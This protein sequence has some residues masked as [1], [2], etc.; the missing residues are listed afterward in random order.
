MIYQDFQELKEKVLSSSKSIYCAVVFPHDEY[1]MDAVLKAEHDG[2]I[3]PIFIGDEKII[4]SLFRKRKIEATEYPVYNVPYED[5]A[6]ALAIDMVHG[7]DAECILKG[8]IT[9][10][11]FMRELLR[12][13]NKFNEGNIVSLLSFHMLENYH[14]I[15]AF[16][17]T[18][19]CPHPNLKQ[20]TLIL[21]NAVNFLHTIG[22]N[23]PKVAI[24]SPSDAADATLP[25]SIDAAAISNMNEDGSIGGCTICGPISFDAAL[26]KEAATRKN[27]LSPVAGDADL[28]VF[29]SLS[30]ASFTSKAI[31]LVT[32]Q[33][34]GTIM[35]G[36]KVPVILSSR[37]SSAE[38][39]YLGICLVIASMLSSAEEDNN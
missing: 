3:H 11:T 31:T 10:Q 14:K 24:L 18:G 1:T 37:A 30:S 12:R 16:T 5:S 39:K 34:P 32:K 28:L 38:T 29:P 19:I 21:E 33:S 26:S 25:E 7:E 9:T 13:E 35:L 6:I 36:T 8:N 27:Y 17:D 22:I 23:K 4:Q 15:V 2:L 20:K